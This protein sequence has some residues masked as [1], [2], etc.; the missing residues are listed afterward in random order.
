MFGLRA[1]TYVEIDGR[2]IMLILTILDIGAGTYV[3]IYSNGPLTI[4]NSQGYNSRHICEWLKYEFPDRSS[5]SAMTA[6][7]SV[8]M[9]ANDGDLTIDTSSINAG[10]FADLYSYYRT[11]I[12]D[13]DIKQAHIL[14]HGADSSYVEVNNSTVKE[15]IMLMYMLKL[16]LI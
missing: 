2:M 12:V 10:S 8:D 3:D 15:K 5:D 9:I 1:G 14:P 6:G 13:S 7:T 11:L 4:Q 16:M